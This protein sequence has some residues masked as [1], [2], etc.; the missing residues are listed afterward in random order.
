MNALG[1]N[2][3]R[4]RAFA[5]VTGAA[6]AVHQLRYLLAYGGHSQEQLSVRPH[7]YLALVVP[8]VGVLALVALAAFA[9]SLL[10]A[11][12]RAPKVSTGPC[13]GTLWVRTSF[14]LL[15]LYS[16]QEWLEGQ[17]G[18][19]HE[20]GIGAIFA[21]GGWWAIPLA[22]ALGAV[23]AW[24]L[25]GAT[26]AVELVAARSRS[27]RWA[28]SSPVRTWQERR[29]PRPALDAVASFLAGRGPPVPSS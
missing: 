1:P 29:S 24:L 23:V 14:S 25:K 17:V 13:A 10:E 22:L 26:I 8:L 2:G 27:R 6:Y 15:G 7:G 3:N 21:S 18:H 4:L 12:R 20:T 19:G 28:A 16:V 11:R 5:L 9:A